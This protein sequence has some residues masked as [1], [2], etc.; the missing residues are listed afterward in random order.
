MIIEKLQNK[1]DRCVFNW[2]Y[3]DSAR[4]GFKAIL[5]TKELSHKRI[6]V[7][8]YIGYSSREGS[9]VFDPIREVGNPY[10]FYHMDNALCIN[11]EDLKAKITA[12][13]GSILLLIHYF[14]FRDKNLEIVKNVAVDN[15]MI[16]IEDF[17]H[18][19]FSFCQN[20]I[21]DFDFGL[22]SIHKLFPTLKGGMILSKT[23]ISA[24]MDGADAKYEMFKYNMHEIIRRRRENYAYLLSE[25][26][27]IS[28][29]YDIRIPSLSENDVP[30]TFPLVVSDNTLRDQLYFQLN[31]EG[32]G[33][34]S[35]YHELISEIDNSF[36][37]ERD[38]SQRIL[39]L[40]LH[41]DVE[42]KALEQMI[43]RLNE[44]VEAYMNNKNLRT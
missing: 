16:I 7:P 14:G 19:Y 32:Y 33:V 43:R 1:N 13:P 26:E 11:T 2:Q 20:P 28:R 6:L 35:L 8:G 27:P 17:A 44:I 15:N 18:A 3:F 34:V 4:D 42:I 22:F 24:G 41:Q 31:K 21:I 25:L 36:T 10:L 9:G 39:N 38:I 23:G 40:P 37:V 30:Q 5:K 29:Q 12:N